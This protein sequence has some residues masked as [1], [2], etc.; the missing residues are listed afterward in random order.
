MLFGLIARSGTF[1]VNAGLVFLLSQQAPKLDWWSTPPKSSV[2]ENA[3]NTVLAG[4]ERVRADLEANGKLWFPGQRAAGALSLN[5]DGE[6][7]PLDQRM[8]R[9]KLVT[10]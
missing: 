5:R 8:P 6:A 1:A 7:H 3:R 10:D 2:F 9:I 4:L